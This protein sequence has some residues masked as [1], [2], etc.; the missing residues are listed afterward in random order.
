MRDVRRQQES[1]EDIFSETF[2]VI[3]GAAVYF[4]KQHRQDGAVRPLFRSASD[5]LMIEQNP[6]IHP[7][8]PPALTQRADHGITG[9]QIVQSRRREKFLLRSQHAPFLCIIKIKIIVQNLLRPGSKLRCQE[10]K[11]EILFVFPVLPK[12]EQWQKLLLL[13]NLNSF[14]HLTVHMNRK[15]RQRQQRPARVIQTKF[16]SKC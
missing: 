9:G 2:P 12:S 7:S 13:L 4:L 10:L 11:E 8:L 16:G 15:I 14:V 5:L 6:E 3:T 1:G